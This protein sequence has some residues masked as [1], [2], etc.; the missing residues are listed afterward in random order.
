VQASL[1][2]YD[3]LQVSGFT[4]GG[5]RQKLE[6]LLASFAEIPKTLYQERLSKVEKGGFFIALVHIMT[7]A[8]HQYAQE[9]TGSGRTCLRLLA[10]LHGHAGMAPLLTAVLAGLA[11]PTTVITAGTATTHGAARGQTY[12]FDKMNIGPKER[13]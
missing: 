13:R 1:R 2:R 10:E 6:I 7:S 11:L 9:V 4:M 8:P 5:M 3:P 12:T